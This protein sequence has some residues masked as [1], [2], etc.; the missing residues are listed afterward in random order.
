MRDMKCANRSHHLSQSHRLLSQN[1][2][3]LLNQNL[4]LQNLSLRFH[5]NQNLQ[6]LSQSLQFHLNQNLRL[7]NQSLQF[8]P[9]QNL[10]L[11]NQNLQC[12]LNQNLRLQNQSHQFPLLLVQI[13][14]SLTMVARFSIS[15]RQIPSTSTISILTMPTEQIMLTLI[16]SPSIHSSLKQHM[17]MLVN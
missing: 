11:Q 12:L 10:R 13:R 14:P 17:S 6:L 5:P 8:H 3:Y 15:K 4:L 7:Q 2:R 16:L 1:H 9:N